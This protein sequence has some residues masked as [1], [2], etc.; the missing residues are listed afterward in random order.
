MTVRKFLQNAV[1]YLNDTS[2]GR[3]DYRTRMEARHIL[4]FVRTFS[5][6]ETGERIPEGTK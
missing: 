1:E 2:F 4:R 5:L 6:Y 3:E